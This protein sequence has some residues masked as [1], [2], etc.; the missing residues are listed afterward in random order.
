MRW[1]LFLSRVAFICNLFSV[2]TLLILWKNII[3]LQALVGTIGIMGY[4]LA[5]VFNPLVN[6]LYALFFLFKRS[7]L[8]V[9][10][11][12]LMVANFLFLLLQALYIFLQNDTFNY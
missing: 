9:I 1:L 8:A 11:G 4:V 7:A 3:Q 12:W 5:I 6:L 2:L 10:P